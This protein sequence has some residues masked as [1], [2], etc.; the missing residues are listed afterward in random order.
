MKKFNEFKSALQKQGLRGVLKLNKFNDNEELVVCLGWDYP[1]KWADKAF[2]AAEK[3]G[4][5]QGEFSIV[6]EISS[7]DIVKSERF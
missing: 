4:L 6:A 3:V 5:K 7:P 1:D 2:N